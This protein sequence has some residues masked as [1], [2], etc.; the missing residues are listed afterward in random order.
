MKFS[1]VLFALVSLCLFS[2]VSFGQVSTLN[3]E[4]R[5]TVDTMCF[6]WHVCAHDSIPISSITLLDDSAGNYGKPPKI[7]HNVHLDQKLDPNNAG[8]IELSGKDSVVCFDVFVSNPLD[9]GYAPLYIV[10]IGGNHSVPIP[11]LRSAAASLRLTKI[12]DFPAKI[13]TLFF[14]TLALGDEICSTLVYINNGHSGGK[15]VTINSASLSKNSGQIT[16]LSTS[17]H[18]PATL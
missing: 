14:P 17:P 18:L 3:N 11:E 1:L 2:D 16:L 10:D 15:S 9:T 5:V 8:V 13:D 7:F 6:S 12:P 4:A